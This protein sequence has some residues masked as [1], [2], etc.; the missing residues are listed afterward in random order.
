M[1]NQASQKIIAQKLIQANPQTKADLNAFM[2]Q[3]CTEFKIPYPDNLRL[4]S[5]LSEVSEGLT[6]ARR[7]DLRNLRKFRKARKEAGGCSDREFSVLWR[8]SA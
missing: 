1:E 6:F 2:R 7:L 5:A 3:I 8:F 4:L